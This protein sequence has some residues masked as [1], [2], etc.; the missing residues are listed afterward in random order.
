MITETQEVYLGKKERLEA[1]RVRRENPPKKISNAHLPAGS[2]MYFY[3]KSCGH[4]A[5]TKPESFVSQVKKL[6]VECQE[7]K[8]CG[9]LE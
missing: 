2:P 3:C 1:L 9:W 5:D 6:C 7:L 8:D 4:L